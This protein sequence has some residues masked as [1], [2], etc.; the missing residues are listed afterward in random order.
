MALFNTDFIASVAPLRYS[1]FAFPPEDRAAIF[2]PVL[3]CYE[4]TTDNE[5]IV[6]MEQTELRSTL[7]PTHELR[8]AAKT[9]SVTQ[10]IY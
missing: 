2:K 4:T 9:L 7:P 6:T 10:V 5:E 1:Q 3:S 8:R